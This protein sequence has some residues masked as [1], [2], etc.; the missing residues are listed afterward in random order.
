MLWSCG[1]VTNASLAHLSRVHTLSF[2]DSPYVSDDG[3]RHLRGCTRI[4]LDSLPAV[5]DAGL[6]HL[7][8]AVDAHF[9][10]LPQ[11]TDV[12]VS[13]LA[14]VHQL[15][16]HYCDGVRGDGLTGL[17]QL[18]ALELLDVLFD[19]HFARSLPAKRRLDLFLRWYPSDIPAHGAAYWQA[20]GEGLSELAEGAVF[21][22][23]LH[24]CGV[25]DAHFALTP[26]ADV[27][28]L[29]FWRCPN[30]TDSILTHPY[31]LL[32]R[33]LEVAECPGFSGR[34]FRHLY[35][36]RFLKARDC[37]NVKAKHIG[38]AANFFGSRLHLISV[39][40]CPLATHDAV[41]ALLPQW[42]VPQSA[43]GQFVV[44]PDF[45]HDL[46]AVDSHMDDSSYENEGASSGGSGDTDSSATSSDSSG[47]SARDSSDS[48][49]ST[50]ST[51]SS[52]SGSDSDSDS[53][54]SA[55]GESSSSE[56]S[57]SSGSAAAANEEP[58]SPQPAPQRAGV[59]RAREEDPDDGGGA[60][61]GSGGGVGAGA[62]GRR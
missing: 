21:R 40:G 22:L 38:A 60:R 20:V 14:G 3:L 34:G 29:D 49:D 9:A 28:L 52:S 17:A 32:L 46:D 39:V 11:L 55:S 31:A 2:S 42:F 48:S 1:R 18:E 45:E 59:K 25:N 7:S 43:N 62:G 4:H 30:L 61:G 36:L 27:L 56:G 5:T 26:L 54:G 15:R 24:G 33:S 35:N 19:A 44:A 16:L 37:P 53:S 50:S 41:L 51:S 10:S 8:G 12:G 6:A 47:S 23:S 13:Q 57:N 58:P